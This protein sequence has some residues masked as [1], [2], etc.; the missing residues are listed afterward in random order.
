MQETFYRLWRYGDSF[1]AAE[2]QLAWLWRVA[3]R[4]C[5]DALS[6][7]H[8]VERAAEASIAADAVAAER[9]PA[10]DLALGERQ[11]ALRMLGRFE[12]R[13]QQVAVLHYVGEM[14]QDE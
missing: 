3:D 9:A 12:P 14:T 5:F 2:S 1:L 7:R 11:E 13:V 6:Q 8:N 10:A 4:C